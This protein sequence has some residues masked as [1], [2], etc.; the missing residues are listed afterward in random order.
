M[1]NLIPPPEII[2]PEVFVGK[3]VTYRKRSTKRRSR[4][5]IEV[6]ATDRAAEALQEAAWR[7]RVKPVQIVKA[8][9]IPLY[10]QQMR[11]LHSEDYWFRDIRWAD[12]HPTWFDGPKQK[13]DRDVKLYVHKDNIFIFTGTASYVEF[14][15]DLIH[16]DDEED[17]RAG[18]GWY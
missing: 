10:L 5:K 7:R 3:H 13:K 16:E 4:L 15:V 2:V 11:L 17:A 6:R 8:Q 18:Y 14:F 9:H 1:A 12:R